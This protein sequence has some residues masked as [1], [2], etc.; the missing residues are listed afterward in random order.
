VGCRGRDDRSRLLR[1]VAEPGGT[2]VV[3]VPDP[4]RRMPGRGASL[5]LDTGCLDLAERRRV[6]ARALRVQGPV[7]TTAVRVYVEEYVERHRE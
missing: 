1:V 5:H 7:D 3:L 6:F 4:R 2:P